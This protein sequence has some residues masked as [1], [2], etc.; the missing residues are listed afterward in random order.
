[1]KTLGP[2]TKAAIKRLV[3]TLPYLKAEGT[4]VP[5]ATRG[6]WQEI[7][8]KYGQDHFGDGTGDPLFSAAQRHAEEQLAAAMEQD[9][10]SEQSEPAPEEQ[11]A[12][13]QE[14]S[15]EELDRL[16]APVTYKEG[17]E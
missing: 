16:T 5:E 12:D 6:H 10:S 7:K 15:D 1:M 17:A 13:Q 14:T 2:A 11:Q 3:D 4:A 9:E 8:T